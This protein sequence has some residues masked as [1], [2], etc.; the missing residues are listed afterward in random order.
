[1]EFGETEKVPSEREGFFSVMTKE[2][3]EVIEV[4]EMI[5]LLISLWEIGLGFIGLIAPAVLFTMWRQW[6][7]FGEP[8]IRLQDVKDIM[9]PEQRK[10]ENN[11]DT[12]RPIPPTGGSGVSNGNKINLKMI[13]IPESK[14]NTGGFGELVCMAERLRQCENQ[15]MA[16]QSQIQNLYNVFN[17]PTPQ[18]LNCEKMLCEQELINLC[19]LYLI[20]QNTNMKNEGKSPR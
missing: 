17:E 6:E 7:D 15:Q 1:M 9:I 3:V 8:R 13:E 19:V 4:I 11:R 16:T 14:I 10:K 2:K 18:M 5:D 12:S 20:Y